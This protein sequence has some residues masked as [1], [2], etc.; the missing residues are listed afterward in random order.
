MSQPSQLYVEAHAKWNAW[1]T[2]SSKVF[3]TRDAMKKYI[4]A[5][6]RYCPGF[7]ADAS[8]PEQ[9]GGSEIGSSIDGLSQPERKPAPQG[10]GLTVSTMQ[11]PEALEETERDLMFFAG[12]GHIAQCEKLVQAKAD[13]A[14]HHPEADGATA[15]HVACERGHEQLAQKLIEWG[16]VVDVID[17]DGQTPLHY[18]IENSQIELAKTLLSFKADPQKEDDDG[19]SPL[20]CANTMQKEKLKM[21]L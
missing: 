4:E 19:N 14:Q 11:V 16:C 17:D 20:D 13:V 6:E 8:G 18:A 5:V 15:L 9:G 7:S 3:N 21:Y 1:N 2:A 12:E 10:M